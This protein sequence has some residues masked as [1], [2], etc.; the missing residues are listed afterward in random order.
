EVSPNA[1]QEPSVQGE[2]PKANT[3]LVIGMFPLM[4]KSSVEVPSTDTT[5]LVS[6]SDHVLIENCEALESS[7]SSQKTAPSDNDTSPPVDMV[8]DVPAQCSLV[9][10]DIAL[11]GCTGTNTEM[12]PSHNSDLIVE[13]KKDLSV[14][15]PDTEPEVNEVKDPETQTSPDVTCVLADPSTLVSPATEEHRPEGC[16]QNGISAGMEAGEDPKPQSFHSDCSRI[17][18]E[19]SSHDVSVFSVGSLSFVT[20]TPVPG[21]NNF[22]F[23]K[24]NVSIGSVSDE[25]AHKVPRLQGKIPQ[26]GY[27][28]ASAVACNDKGKA[29]AWPAEV[30]SLK[31]SIAPLPKAVPPTSGI[32]SARRSLALCQNP[33]APK[34]A[35]RGIPGRGTIRPPMVRQGV[36]R[37]S[38]GNPTQAMEGTGGS[39]VTNKVSGIRSK[40][41]K[42][43]SAIV[44]ARS[45][46]PH[47]P[48]PAPPAAVKP[49]S[50]LGAP[51]A[52][53]RPSTGGQN[54]AARPSSSTGIRTGLPRPG[55]SSITRP[56]PHSQRV[57][58]KHQK[59]L[60]G[61]TTKQNRRE[62]PT[63]RRD[64]VSK[65]DGTLVG[66]SS[67]K[68][69]TLASG[70]A[71]VVCAEATVQIC[72]VQ[73]SPSSAEGIAAT[74][75]IPT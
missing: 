30:I 59:S 4:Q 73:A 37:P 14:S 75:A 56:L 67:A 26:P 43:A 58:P 47:S 54:N 74:P 46:G 19:E 66:R 10:E 65:T 53:G 57:S 69:E 64:I 17:Q 35:P 12:P 49:P 6:C 70:T 22:P 9:T 8:V 1:A 24:A 21:L 20:S 2:V 63:L 15:K 11:P 72:E 60:Q 61:L 50:R 36:P 48:P 40:N 31:R 32:P 62:L 29:S 38:L 16:G 13:N 44:K 27:P 28:D 3:T 7:D 25:A 34:P 5:I 41:P 52:S 55:T 18:E 45:S 39:N 68:P 51:G 71:K 23:Q 42:A 33:A